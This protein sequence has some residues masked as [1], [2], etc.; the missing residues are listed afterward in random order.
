MYWKIS[1][2]KLICQI[3]ASFNYSTCAV[4]GLLDLSAMRLSNEWFGAFDQSRL[5]YHSIITI[6]ITWSTTLYRH[7]IEC[8]CAVLGFFY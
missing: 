1:I 2:Y 3:D 5:S 6:Y 7:Q 4:W 8:C